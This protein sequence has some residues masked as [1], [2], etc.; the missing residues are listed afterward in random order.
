MWK[1]IPSCPGYEAAANG[2]IR[3]IR[4]TKIRSNGWPHTTPERQLALHPD[5][6]GYLCFRPWING[7]HKNKVVHRAVYEA[8]NG[9]IPAGLDLD[10]I[11]GNPLNNSLS[12]LQA[13]SRIDHAKKT[14]DKIK[15]DAFNEGYVQA[16][17]DF[18]K[19]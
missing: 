3:S 6:Q 16:L 18:N 17:K 15:Q 19:E 8:F 5:T 4:R 10:H 9:S 1:S 2:Q 14:L 7:I 12:N 11:D 13:L